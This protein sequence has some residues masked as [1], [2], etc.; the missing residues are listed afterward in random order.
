MNDTRVMETVSLEIEVLIRGEQLDYIA[1]TMAQAA[2]WNILTQKLPGEDNGP[3]VIEAV[4]NITF[5]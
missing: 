5:V 4:D 2:I 3:C 1:Q